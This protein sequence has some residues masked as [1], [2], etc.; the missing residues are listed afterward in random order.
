MSH[1]AID[2]IGQPWVR[3][4]HDCWAFFRRVQSEQ[5]GRF[6]PEIP[7][8]SYRRMVVQDLIEG[9]AERNNWLP[10][11]TPSEGDAVLLAHAQHPSHIGV[12]VDVDGGGVLHCV[13][14]SGVVFQNTKNLKATGWG[15]LEFYRHV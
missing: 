11:D 6:V 10:V 13:G 4:T 7:I 14:W 3:H 15:H 1:W 9:H 12:W 2:Y 5:F 8:D